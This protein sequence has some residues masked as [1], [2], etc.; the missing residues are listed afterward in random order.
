LSAFAVHNEPKLPSRP[1]FDVEAAVSKKR[2]QPAPLL[3]L[4]VQPTPRHSRGAAAIHGCNGIV[5]LVWEDE[6]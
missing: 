6:D 5:G 1:Q 4:L 2:S 3:W